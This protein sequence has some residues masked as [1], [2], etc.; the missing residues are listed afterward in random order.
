MTDTN[1]ALVPHVKLA[2][3]LLNKISFRASD[4]E[5]LSIQI[6]KK[7]EKK[8]TT[9]EKSEPLTYSIKLGFNPARTTV[10]DKE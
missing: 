8:K 9:L 3:K 6:Q 4:I 1:N 5:N 7:K 2:V 10:T